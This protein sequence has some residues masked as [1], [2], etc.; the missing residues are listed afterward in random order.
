MDETVPV[1]EETKRGFWSWLGLSAQFVVLAGL[2]LLGAAAASADRRPGDYLCGVL[3]S[4]AAIALGFI[5]LKHFFDGG[6]PGLDGFLLVDDMRGLVVAVPVFVVIGLAGLFVAHAWE[7]GSMH[8]AGIA[9]FVASGLIVF[10]DL[11][12]VFDRIDAGAG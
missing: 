4:V 5:R 2:A 12:R 3:L 11:K 1:T 8:A 10:L 9:L 6:P 7:S